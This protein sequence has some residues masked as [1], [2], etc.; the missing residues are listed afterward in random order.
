MW[1]YEMTELLDIGLGV[2]MLGRDLPQLQDVIG[3]FQNV[4]CVRTRLHG[5]S[6]FLDVLERVK[7]SFAQMKNLSDCVSF[8]HATWATSMRS[9]D[10]SDVTSM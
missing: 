3:N 5:C 1:Q 8:D 9:R 2:T 6:T 7:G 10:C 4:S